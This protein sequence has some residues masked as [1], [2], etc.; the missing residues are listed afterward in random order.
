MFIASIARGLLVAAVV[1][2]GVLAP[3]DTPLDEQIKQLERDRQ[4]AFI[5]GDI[6]RLEQDTADD[7]TTINGAGAVSDK[8]RMMARLRSG[9]TK[10]VSVTLDD[11][12]TRVYGEVAVLTGIYRDVSIVE[13]VEKHVSARFTR[14]FVKKPAGWQAVA[15][16]Q[17]PLPQ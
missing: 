10:V 8:P 16:Q 3:Q 1:G 4:Q 14:V 2:L 15:Y 13:G 9:R 12:K 6:A 5:R 7:Y 17:T 11:L